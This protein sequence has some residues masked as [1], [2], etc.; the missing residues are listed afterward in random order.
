VGK[1]KWADTVGKFASKSELDDI[2][3]VAKDLAG[4]VES[5]A[6]EADH[7]LTPNALMVA[8]LGKSQLA[9]LVV[10]AAFGGRYEKVDPLAIVV[11]RE[12]LNYTSAHLDALFAMQGIGSFAL[13]QAGSDRL[14][15]EWLPKVAR[16]EA[17]AAMA[18]TEPE[19][20]S[21]LKA[22]ATT[23]TQDGDELVLN[24]YKSFITNSGCAAFYEVLAREGDD[25]SMIFVPAGAAGL[26]TSVGPQIM[27]P[28]LI[29]DMTF[30]NVRVP[31][32]CRIG[33]R[34]AGFSLALATLAVFRVSVAGAAVGL[35]QS[36][37]DEAVRHTSTRFQFGKPLSDIGAVA[38]LLGKCWID[39][40]TSRAIAYRAAEMAREDSMG[41]LHMS[42]I[43]K[44]GASEAAGRVVDAA[45]QVMGRSGLITG[46][47]IERL[48]RNARP[49]R[50]Y[51]GGSEVVL[52]SLA[53]KL[54]KMSGSAAA[55]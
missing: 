41:N 2:R 15:Q 52:D 14:R 9:E 28:H 51:E 31:L 8:E 38:N 48:Y 45:V 44:V 35:A 25:F 18:L 36:A 4:R 27:A 1:Q 49:L 13:A 40:E 16:M 23:V 43:A 10:P 22:I 12:A 20:G 6:F 32:D 17:L 55:K 34:G 19:A 37:L 47:N 42:S 30:D 5:A 53:R 54:V 46:S 39:V 11:T 7:S 29:G 50:I 21:D 3:L 24:G 26:T 33:A